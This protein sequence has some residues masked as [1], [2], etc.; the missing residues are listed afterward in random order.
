MIIPKAGAYFITICTRD[1]ECLL[2]KVVNGTVQLNETGRLVESVWLQT[3]TVRPEIDQ[4]AFGVMPNHL[5]G[6]SFAMK[7]LGTIRRV[8]LSI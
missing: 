4:D 5:D 8:S 6:S 3:A 7:W 1:R 2:G